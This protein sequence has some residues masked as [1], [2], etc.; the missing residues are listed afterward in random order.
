MKSPGFSWLMSLVPIRIIGTGAAGLAAALRLH[1]YG[2]GNVRILVAHGRS[3]GRVSSKKFGGRK[4]S[5]PEASL[6]FSS[7]VLRKLRSK[8]LRREHHQEISDGKFRNNRRGWV[9]RTPC[10]A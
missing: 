8:K 5:L 7:H 1:E 4:R 10:P 3:G 9:P 2:F 6:Q